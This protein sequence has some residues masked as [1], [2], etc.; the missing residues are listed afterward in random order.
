MNNELRFDTV[1]VA[2]AATQEELLCI[3][4]N[5]MNNKDKIVEYLSNMATKESLNTVSYCC[6]ILFLFLLIIFLHM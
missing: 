2:Q 6:S 3:I 5:V 4:T 1:E